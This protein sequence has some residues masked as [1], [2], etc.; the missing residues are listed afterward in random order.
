MKITRRQLRRLI[1]EAKFTP[2][3]PLDRDA[4]QIAL[5]THPQQLQRAEIEAEIRKHPHYEEG[6]VDL[7]DY[8]DTNAD[9]KWS[10]NPGEHIDTVV[11]NATAFLSGV[12]SW[13]NSPNGIVD[14]PITEEHVQLMLQDLLDA[15]YLIVNANDIVLPTTEGEDW[16]Y[17]TR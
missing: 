17:S 8:I 11:L 2:S 4:I 6:K 13:S 14:D 10:V 3:R 5:G 16:Y 1:A 9:P 12:Y 15:G 7:F